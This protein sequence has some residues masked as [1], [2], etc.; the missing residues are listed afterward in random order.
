VNYPALCECAHRERV[1]RVACS[2]LTFS[3]MG[4]EMD[5][6]EQPLLPTAAQLD[7]EDADAMW[8]EEK[9]MEELQTLDALR[10]FLKPIKSQKYAEIMME[11]GYDDV[12]FF[13]RVRRARHTGV[14]SS[15]PLPAHSAQ[16]ADS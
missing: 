12:E 11:L 15:M 13:E 9:M 3:L 8:G 1:D 16:L 7:E 4:D 2:T 10:K 6:A 14:S 5:E